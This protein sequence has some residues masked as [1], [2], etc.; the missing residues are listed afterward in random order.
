ML[1]ATLKQ[2]LGQPLHPRKEDEFNVEGAYAALVREQI[3]E[4]MQHQ[5]IMRLPFTST[6]PVSQLLMQHTVSMLLH[7]CNRHARM[8]GQLGLACKLP[9]MQ[10]VPS[11]CQHRKC[12]TH[13]STRSTQVLRR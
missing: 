9:L 7:V 11:S 8:G 10:Y 4:V 6:L 3:A 5:K 1:Q 2:Y 13:L 12:A